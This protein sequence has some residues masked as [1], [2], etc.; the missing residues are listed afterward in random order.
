MSLWTRQWY[1][2][3]HVILHMIIACNIRASQVIY[4]FNQP[5]VG[6][7]DHLCLLKRWTIICW[8]LCRTTVTKDSFLML[9]AIIAWYSIKFIYIPRIDMYK[10]SSI[11]VYI[12]TCAWG[13][14][15]VGVKVNGNVAVL[16]KKHD[17]PFA[18]QFM[19]PPILHQSW[20]WPSLRRPSRQWQPLRPR[21][22][23]FTP[24][25]ATVTPRRFERFMI[26]RVWYSLMVS[27]CNLMEI[28]W[29]LGFNSYWLRLSKYSKL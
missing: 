3:F 9:F 19:F 23:P 24:G 16:L 4:G 27:N 15:M 7:D 20:R 29:G 6:D 11:N 17:T 21:P 13:V 14:H 25:K 22:R 8:D 5:K 1:S 26:K 28:Y 10:P 12:Q 2:G 18:I